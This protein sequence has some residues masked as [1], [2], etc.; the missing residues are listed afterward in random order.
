MSRLL[1]KVVTTW[2]D[3]NPIAGVGFF[4]FSMFYVLLYE[5]SLNIKDFSM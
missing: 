2:D 4:T 5:R 1:A 3:H